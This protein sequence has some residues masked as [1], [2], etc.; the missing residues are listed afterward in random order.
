MTAATPLELLGEL[1]LKIHG[2]PCQIYVEKPDGIWTL[3]TNVGLPALSCDCWKSKLPALR[4]SLESAALE[5]KALRE[6]ED[7]RDRHHNV[8]D[9]LLRKVL[10]IAQEPSKKR[11]KDSDEIIAEI[12]KIPDEWNKACR[13]I[14]AI[15]TPPATG[16][17]E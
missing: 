6:R 12:L 3:R 8:A 15:R 1:E 11:Y 7:L 10:C 5:A 2:H 13:E 16:R 17:G 9:F 14:S 4:A